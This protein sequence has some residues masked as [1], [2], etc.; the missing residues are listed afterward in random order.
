MVHTY[1]LTATRTIGARQAPARPG[2]LQSNPSWPVRR[3]SPGASLARVRTGPSRM[4]E[5]ICLGGVGRPRPR[6]PAVLHGEGRVKHR[7]RLGVPSVSVTVIGAAGP[8]SWAELGGR[9]RGTAGT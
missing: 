2:H 5:I 6:R 8:E 4:P 1:C 7:N 3:A 9:V